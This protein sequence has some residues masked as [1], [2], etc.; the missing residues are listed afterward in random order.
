[1][2]SI[3]K[4][5]M[6]NIINNILNNSIGKSFNTTNLQQ[7]GVADIIEKYICEQI[8]KIDNKE[9]IIEQSKTK[10]SLE[11]VQIKNNQEL[12]KIDIKTH[13]LNSDFSMPNLISVDRLK[14]FYENNNNHLMYI[15][16]SY[17]TNNNITQIKNIEIRYIEE[18]S[19][20]IL[21]IQ[22]LGKG[23]LQI[24]NM[25]NELIFVE[26]NREEWINT[27]KQ[28]MIKFYKKQII[29]TQKLIDDLV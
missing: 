21:G 5:T 22:N 20:E 3:I 9:L 18:L 19:W 24:K 4:K 12:Y 6:K 27:L 13:D 26:P 23:Q 17:T 14:K 11:D 7:R 28:N 8:I 25:N 29:K 1:M 15:I 2:R 16:I 10:K